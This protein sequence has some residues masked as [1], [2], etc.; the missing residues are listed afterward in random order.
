MNWIQ[1]FLTAIAT[2]KGDASAHHPQA[3]TLGSHS[4]KAHTELTGVTTSQHHT[5][6]TNASAKAAA[7]QAGAITNGVTKAPTHD[8]VYD[9]KVTADTATTPAEV[10]AKI[11]THKGDA[12]AH[13]TP[14]TTRTIATGSYVGN[15]T[16]GRQIAV[17]FKCSLV[18][19]LRSAA[20]RQWTL[21]PN[22]TVIHYEVS[23]YHSD[24]V[25]KVYLHATNGFVVDSAE[26]EANQSAATYYYW[27]ISE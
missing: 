27:A 19:I 16:S 11:T 12:N 1:R 15:A 2:H 24:R 18:I 13:H 6:Y 22:G 4:T 25:E 9:V 3:H 5:K 23:P 14:P 10:D 21:I 17:G 8:A 7:V 20:G 26:Y